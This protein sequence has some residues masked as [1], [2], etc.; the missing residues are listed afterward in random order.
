MTLMNT[1]SK[2]TASKIKSHLYLYE[3]QKLHSLQMV[4]F[5]KKIF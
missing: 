4:F 2:W 5:L 3:N 1:A